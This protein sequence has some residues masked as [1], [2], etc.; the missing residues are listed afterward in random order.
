MLE[1]VLVVGAQFT[2]ELT[3]LIEQA[4]ETIQAADFRKEKAGEAVKIRVESPTHAHFNFR[5]TL[6]VEV[7][8]VQLAE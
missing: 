4:K 8:R 5:K 6:D 2:S 1:R 3:V 7:V